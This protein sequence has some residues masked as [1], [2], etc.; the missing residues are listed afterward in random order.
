MKMAGHTPHRPAWP[1]GRREGNA[2]QNL[3]IGYEDYKRM[4]D[5]DCYYVDKTQMIQEL[6][7]NRAMVTLF[8]RPR[9]FGKTLA[10]SMLRTFFEKE[11][12]RDGNPVDNSRYFEGKKIMSADPSILSRMGQYPVIHLS[13]KSAKKSNFK[14]SFLKIREAIIKEYDRHRYLACSNTLSLREKEIF[15]ELLSGAS[16]QELRD[17][18]RFDE[19]VENYTSSIML[20]SMYLEKHHEKK[21]VILIDEYD[22]PLETAYYNGFYREMVDFIR[23]LFESALKTNDA[24]EFAVITGCLRISKESIFTG[25]NNLKIK[26]IRENSFSEYFG[27]TQQETERALVNFGIAD[28]VEEVK[29]WYDGYLFGKKEIYNP[30]SVLCYIEGVTKDEKECPEPYWPNTSS[31]QIIKDMIGH[32]GKSVRDELDCLVN[33]GTIEKCI[34][35][36]ITYDDIHESD[37]NFWNFLFFT[38]Y[39]KK[40]SERKDGTRIYM[41][42]K[43]PNMEVQ[44]IYETQIME[45]LETI[46][47]DT[48]R[49]E[50]YK[51]VLEED[52]ANMKGYITQLLKK[53]ISTFDSAESFYHGFLLSLLLD[54][55]DYEVKSNREEG[56]GR[57]DIVLYPNTE[58]LPVVV[59]EVKA[60]KTF[61]E[62]QTGLKKALTQIGDKDYIGG[63]MADGYEKVIAYGICFCKKSCVVEKYGD[64]P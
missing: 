22:V 45:W 62:M 1:L 11:F 12:D 56:N 59:F 38:G 40:V 21:V 46:V 29:K 23:S 34:H 10:L 44:Y 43:I 20:L 8:T 57:P 7:Q 33:G 49:T 26:S 5:D 24:L 50:L 32:A 54:M 53:S 17:N 39:M 63:I 48:D 4:M 14:A 2:V 47:K 19:E 25:L 9:R 41:T 36:N 52:L 60:C 28:K 3:G 61:K 64:L 51:A 31:N 27:F 6:M 15:N 58:D 18:E 37:D 55:E 13:L 30:W 35:E 16:N 42:M